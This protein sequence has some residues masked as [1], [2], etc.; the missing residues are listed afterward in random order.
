MPSNRCPHLRAKR[1]PP[2]NTAA[3]SCA[4]KVMWRLVCPAARI[5]LLMPV[6]AMINRAQCHKL[7]AVQHDINTRNAGA[8]QRGLQIMNFLHMKRSLLACVWEAGSCEAGV[9]GV[10][11]TV[12]LRS[13]TVHSCP[14]PTSAQTRA[15]CSPCCMLL[16][17]SSTPQ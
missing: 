1:V 7:S 13:P 3:A 11:H 16:T 15:C 9:P 5:L 14:C 17:T 2:G 8:E 4:Q 12:R 6:D 10:S